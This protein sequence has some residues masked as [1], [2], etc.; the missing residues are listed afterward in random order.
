MAIRVEREGIVTRLSEGDVKKILDVHPEFKKN[1]IITWEGTLYALDGTQIG[2]ETPPEPQLSPSFQMKAVQAAFGG[3]SLS[4]HW[5]ELDDY[6]NHKSRPSSAPQVRLTP[7]QLMA[8]FRKGFEQNQALAMR[9]DP[10]LAIGYERAAY[11]AFTRGSAKPEIDSFLAVPVNSKRPEAD[12]EAKEQALQERRSRERLLNQALHDRLSGRLV[13]YFPANEAGQELTE[14]RAY[15]L[16]A[17]FD[18]QA[19][20]AGYSALAF[21]KFLTNA[22]LPGEQGK[23]AASAFSS[24]LG[25]Q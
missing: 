12:L 18:P 6:I 25:H 24:L 17:E 13:Q 8:S 15:R 2:L 3:P 14:D 22:Q 16:A 19:F 5:T 4:S 1:G 11:N 9:A 7:D 21:Q 10:S 20:A 23:N